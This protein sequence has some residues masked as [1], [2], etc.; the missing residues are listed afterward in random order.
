MIYARARV[1][2][3]APAYNHWR[4]LIETM[5]Y[6]GLGPFMLVDDSMADQV[7]HRISLNAGGAARSKGC[8]FDPRP[9]W[10]ENSFYNDGGHSL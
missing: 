9:W 3:I 4:V 8:E 7:E 2:I 6:A 10:S 5:K 1:I